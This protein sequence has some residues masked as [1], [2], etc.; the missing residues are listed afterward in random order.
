MP[1][2]KAATLKKIAEAA[3]GLEAERNRIVHGCWLPTGKPHT[4]QR[5][6][7][8]AYGEFV[9]KK[10]N[11][12]AKR[13]DGHTAEVVKLARRLNYALERQGFWRSLN[14]SQETPPPEA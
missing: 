9:Q 12:S 6:S 5:Y 14:S 4:A 7:Y 1:P 13:I 11:V 3:K 8:R 10:E 2:R